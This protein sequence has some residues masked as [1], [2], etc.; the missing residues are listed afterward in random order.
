MGFELTKG[1]KKNLDHL[2]KMSVDCCWFFFTM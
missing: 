2:K 1:L